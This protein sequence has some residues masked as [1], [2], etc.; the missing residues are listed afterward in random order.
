MQA[1]LEEVAGP[2]AGEESK[3]AFISGMRVVAVDGMC[4][5]LPDTDE[6]GAEFGYPRNGERRGPFPQIR[7]VA[8][9]ECGTRS[10]LGAT[11]SGLATGEQP[12]TRKL[13]GKLSP[14]DLLLADRNFLSH[15]LL[16]DVPDRKIHVLWRAVEALGLTRALIDLSLAVASQVAKLTDRLWRNE[17]W[18]YQ[19]VLEELTDPRGIADIG[20]A[21]RHIAHVAGVQQSA[22][23][24]VFEHVVNRLPVDASRL[25]ADKAYPLFDNPVLQVQ[26]RRGCRSKGPHLLIT[27]TSFP[28]C[29]HVRRRPSLC[30]RRDRSSVRRVCPCS[31]RTPLFD[32]DQAGVPGGASCSGI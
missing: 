32:A 29:A 20:L 15:G 6:N 17:A 28:L 30:E 21:S 9:A 26:Q 4:L 18:S 12:L 22:F 13:L 3:S 25:H 1:L 24:C 5:D 7:V 23:N 11:T 8:L 27:F 31:F 14:G 16:K 10:V 19:A 2:L